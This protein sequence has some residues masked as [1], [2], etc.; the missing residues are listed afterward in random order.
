MPV[1]EPILPALYSYYLAT[2]TAFIMPLLYK[3]QLK[4]AL[5]KADLSTITAPTTSLLPNIDHYSGGKSRSWKSVRGN[6]EKSQHFR[7]KC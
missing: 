6:D 4:T 5:I 3:D 7:R 2:Q 1:T